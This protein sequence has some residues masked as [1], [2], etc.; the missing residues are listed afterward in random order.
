MNATP[1]VPAACFLA[2]D[3]GQTQDYSALAVVARRRP[4]GPTAPPHFSVSYLR[5]W[6]LGTSYT[7]V[8]ADV[9]RLVK[10]PPL[11]NPILGIDQTGVGSAVVDMFRAARPS[12]R[13]QP[14]LITGG[15]ATRKDDAGAWHIPKK[16]LVSALQAP[17]SGRRLAIADLPE[18]ETLVREL[19]AFKVKVSTAGAET[20]EA[21]RERDHDDLVLAVC[22]AVWL[23][24]R[25]SPGGYAAGGERPTCTPP[26]LAGGAPPEWWSQWDP[27]CRG[28]GF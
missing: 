23:G 28:R 6:S 8:V 9:A 10:R 19:L 1:T 3:L 16:E 18:R 13:L 17:L 25:P 24:S 20:F 12:A 21:W 15:H 11:R 2:L 5:R 22:I 27:A 26:F 4:D 7:A 14:V